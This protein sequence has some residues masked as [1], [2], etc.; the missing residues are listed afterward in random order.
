M[1]IVYM[2]TAYK[3]L[4]ITHTNNE[5]LYNIEE[6]QKTR[7]NE[8]LKKLK[9]LNI[10]LFPMLKIEFIK[11]KSLLEELSNGNELLCIIYVTDLNTIILNNGKY[12]FFEKPIDAFKW[13]Y[14]Y[15]KE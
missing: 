11:Y 10:P 15:T 5:E 1:S 8:L 13:C 6:I 9:E 2:Y 7:D 4:K 12:I 14:N 3:D